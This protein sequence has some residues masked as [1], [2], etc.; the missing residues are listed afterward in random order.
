MLDAVLAVPMLREG[1]VTGWLAVRSKASGGALSSDDLDVLRTLANESAVALANATAVDQL[2]EARTQ[3]AHAERLAA[4]G[5]LS[6]AVAHGIRNP[7]ASIRLAAQLGLESAGA[8]DVRENLEDVLHAVDKLE[9]QVRGVLDFAR[10]FEPRLEPVSVAELTR[11]VLDAAAG[12]LRTSGVTVGVDLPPSLP[13][14]LADRAHLGQALQELI[15]NA[16]DAMPQGGRLA[17]DARAEDGDSPV[18]RLAVEDEG[19][20]VPPDVGDRIFQLF[21][22]TKATGTGVGLAVVRKIV[23]R[24][25]GRVLLERHA[26]R[27]ARFVLEVPAAPAA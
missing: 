10:P 4:I 19:P 13:P 12:R 3:L 21:T 2:G 27:G 7:L 9:T 24:H 15:A 16:I 11:T 6:T 26:G 8:A 5:E 17:I 1:R 23:E 20:G 14:V 22:T 25:G 18:V